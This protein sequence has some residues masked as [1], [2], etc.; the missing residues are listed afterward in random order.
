MKCVWVGTFAIALSVNAA[1][2]LSEE[3][4]SAIYP[5]MTER[6]PVPLNMQLPL[7]KPAQQIEAGQA[8][9]VLVEDIPYPEFKPLLCKMLASGH[10]V[11]TFENYAKTIG[12]HA[13][14][15]TCLD[16]AFTKFIFDVPHAF[17]IDSKLTHQ[18]KVAVLYHE[19]QHLE[20]L[21]TGEATSAE[22][23]MPSPVDRWIADLWSHTKRNFLSE[24]N[25]YC[26]ECRLAHQQGWS[27][28]MPVC[29]DYEANGIRGLAFYLMRTQLSKNVYG[30]NARFMEEWM[31]E[32][33]LTR[34]TPEELA[35]DRS[36]I[37]EIQATGNFSVVTPAQYDEVRTKLLSLLKVHPRNEVAE[38]AM[39]LEE[40]LLILRCSQNVENGEL[41]KGATYFATFVTPEG[42]QYP[43]L[44]LGYRFMTDT[45]V[46]DQERMAALW[47]EYQ[48]LL[49]LTAQA[50]AVAR[51][52]P[53]AKLPDELMARYTYLSELNA[54]RAECQLVSDM[55]WQTQ[56]CMEIGKLDEQ[57]PGRYA[58]RMLQD[59]DW[60]KFGE[61]IRQVALEQKVS[62]TQGK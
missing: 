9:W 3:W 41:R 13:T 52:N 47:H 28:S 4:K 8:F 39:L 7:L 11:L 25:A 46:S 51:W 30:P 36:R 24:L 53:F 45:T 32:F 20:E 43:I 57:F 27:L 1:S 10:V 26:E 37:S 6:N 33:L 5:G 38:F 58:Q 22:Y 17:L 15:H 14:T 35:L 18:D 31:D 19:F 62:A 12:G 48:H 59:P 40:K 44:N 2:A 49:E 34:S 16:P 21:W 61:L 50:D 54:S 29:Q 23:Q 42:D 56:R 55:Q 60:A